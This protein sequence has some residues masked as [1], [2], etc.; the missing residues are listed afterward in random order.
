MNNDKRDS[1]LTS[2]E[3]KIVKKIYDNLQV[4]QEFSIFWY[5]KKIGD[6]N[7]NI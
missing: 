1:D 7:Y 6:N 4:H 3:I 2:D 5:N